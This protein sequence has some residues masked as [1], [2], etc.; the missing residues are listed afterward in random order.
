MWSSAY[1]RFEVFTANNLIKYSRPI[2]H[3]N[4]EL[5]ENV[6]EV[7]VVVMETEETSETLVFNSTLTRLI[8]RKEFSTS[9][10]VF[11]GRGVYYGADSN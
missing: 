11:L 6:S 9:V 5:K 3:V 2:S 10:C 7:S 4:V 1:V 8:A